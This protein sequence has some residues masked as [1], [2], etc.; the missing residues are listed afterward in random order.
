MDRLAA[1]VLLYRGDGS[2]L[3]LLLVHRAPELRFF[4]DYLALP[5]GVV[6]STDGDPDDPGALRRCAE[7]ELFE[8]TGVVLDSGMRSAPAAQ[9]EAARH[10]MLGSDRAAGQAA[11]ANL[12][13][14]ARGDADLVEL[15][16]IKTPA[17]APV[18]YDTAFFLATLPHGATPDIWPGELVGGRMVTP[19]SALTEWSQGA[20]HIVPPVLVLLELLRSGDIASFRQ[21]AAALAAGFERGKLHRVFFS[22]G[23]LM[24]CLA[25]PTLPPATTTNCFVVGTARLSI[26]DPG[27]PDPAEQAR[28]FE[29]LDELV[30]EGAELEAVVCTH[31][32]PD[33]VGAVRAVSQRY[34]LPVRGHAKTLERLPS[35][36]LLGAPIEDGSRL[37]LGNAP[38]GSPDWHLEAMYTPGHDRGHLAFRDS[39]YGAAIVGDMVSTVATILIDP[40]EGHMATYLASLR[41]LRDTPI[42]T[43]HP[44]HGPAT[45]RARALL[46]KFLAHRQA[47]Q[48][49]L[50][51]ALESG[52]GSVESLLP[53]V[54]SDVPEPMLPYASRALLAG[55]EMSVEE[56][57]VEGDGTTWQL[58]RR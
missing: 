24:A 46:E 27:T 13:T 12:R 55:L 4:G 37:D 50:L 36:C 54:Y 34:Q 25:T 43:L 42:S 7:R 1:A 29:L 41:R 52:P 28:L 32:H 39:R 53:V 23:I 58:V 56:G 10:A 16:R 35:G 9:R 38:D 22:P 8:E 6:D 45:L 51:R 47:R 30:A 26:I 19:R 11:W 17:F 40:P 15:C 3:E 20:C 5:G 21:R 48:T 18:R 57:V 2:A 31:H 33:H 44:A 49:A 14:S